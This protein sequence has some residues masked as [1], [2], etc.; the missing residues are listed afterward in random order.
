MTKR[1]RWRTPSQFGDFKGNGEILK[2][3]RTSFGVFTEGDGRTQCKAV[4]RATGQRC[5]CNAVQGREV[6]R[7]HGGTRNLQRLIEQSGPRVSK[8]SCVSPNNLKRQIDVHG[9]FMI[10]LE[11][12]IPTNER[13]EFAKLGLGA[14]GRKLAQIASRN[15]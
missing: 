4:S 14:R 6:C 1:P 15:D 11:H 8:R 2:R 7:S 10:D 12:M 3:V 13:A 9:A 5:R